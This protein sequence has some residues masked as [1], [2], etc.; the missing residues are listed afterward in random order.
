MDEETKPQEEQT[1]EDSSLFPVEHTPEVDERLKEFGVDLSEPEEEKPAEPPVEE[2]KE[3]TPEVPVEQQPAATPPAEEP[4]ENKISGEDAQA[5]IE[6]QTGEDKKEEEV[7]PWETEGRE[8][9]QKE[10]LD[11]IANKAVDIQEQRQ[12]EAQK[13]EAEKQQAAKAQ[14]EQNVAAWKNKWEG[15][16]KWL[17]AKGYIRKVG[18][19]DDPNDP[20]VK[21]RQKLLEQATL[22]NELDLRVVQL[23]HI[24]PNKG[25]QPAG[26]NAPIS[27][28]SNDTTA[29]EGEDDDFYYDEVHGRNPAE[30]DGVE[31]GK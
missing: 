28:P 15:D 31:L 30:Y 25:K 13:V 16:V 18:N 3:E 1:Q 12:A 2:K 9:T 26:V 27:I 19:K 4:E 11:Y 6:T 17:E 23:V 20:G 5:L 29:A 14:E 21:D 22:N 7:Y 8:P 10:V 24:E